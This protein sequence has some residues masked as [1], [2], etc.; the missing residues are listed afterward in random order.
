MTARENTRLQAAADLR[1]D[2][3]HGDKRAMSRPTPTLPNN[4]A[5][6]IFMRCL[7]SSFEVRL[8]QWPPTL[9]HHFVYQG[10][11]N[12]DSALL[13]GRGFAAVGRRRTVSSGAWVRRGRMGGCG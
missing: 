12:A 13:V 6:R 7:A 4:V 9:L 8:P 5:K 1:A 3:V 10:E 11:P 2:F